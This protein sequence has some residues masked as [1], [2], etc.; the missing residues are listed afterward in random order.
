MGTT[1][2]KTIKVVVQLIKM[3]AE[4]TGQLV[5]HFM[6]SFFSLLQGI[7]VEIFPHEIQFSFISS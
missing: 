4:H 1:H 5:I 3:L 7:K 2:N 6:I